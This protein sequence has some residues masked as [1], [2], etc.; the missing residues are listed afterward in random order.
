MVHVF[1]THLVMY[2]C[3]SVSAGILPPSPAK[4]GAL[5]IE[6]EGQGLCSGDTDSFWQ[7]R[8]E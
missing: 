4:A 7:H 8:P 1:S 3:L 5:C 6:D 2:P